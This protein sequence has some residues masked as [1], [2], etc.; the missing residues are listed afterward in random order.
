MKEYKIEEKGGVSFENLRADRM[1]KEDYIKAHKSLV[2]PCHDVF[3]LYDGG[4]FLIERKNYP[5]KGQLWPVGGRILR[6]I[7]IEESLKLKVK[8]ECNL[9]LKEITE[10]GHV[11]FYDNTDPFGHK[12][13]TDNISFVFFSKASGK[14]KLDENHSGFKIIS[15]SNYTSDFRNSLHPFVKDFMD[16]AMKYLSS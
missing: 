11:R 2:I 15:P 5:S 12:K 1:P 13:G 7:P 3:I 16:K 6:G 8:E 10:L 9:D 4:I 14:I